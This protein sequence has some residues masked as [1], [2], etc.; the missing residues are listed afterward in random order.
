MQTTIGVYEAKTHLPALLRAVQKGNSYA[1]T[2]RGKQIAE[3]TPTRSQREK[4]IH[5]LDA[6]TELQNH[7]LTRGALGGLEFIQTAKARGRR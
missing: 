2:L 1:I 4:I 7:I 6:I 5:T 3:L